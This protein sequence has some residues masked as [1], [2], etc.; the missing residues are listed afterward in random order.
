MTNQS[1]PT[2]NDIKAIV[3]DK[4][5]SFI[6]LQFVDILGHMKNVG[7]TIAEL[8]RVLAQGMVFDG[9]SVEGFVRIEESDM[10]LR[11]DP[12]TFTVLPWYEGHNIARMICDVYRPDGKPFLGDPR[13]VLRKV[14]GEA[15]SLGYDFF[16]GPECEFFLFQCDAQGRPTTNTHDEASYFD[17]APTDNGEL[18]RLDMVKTLMEMGFQIEAAHHESGPGQHEIDFKYSDALRAADNIVTFKLAVKVIAKKYGLHAT[19]MPKPLGAECGSGMHCNMSLFKNGT[20]AFFDVAGVNG[21]SKEAYWFMGGLI[22]HAKGMCAITNP[23]VNSYKRLVPGYEAPV[24]IAWSLANRS[25]LVRIPVARGEGTRLELRHPDPTCNPYLALAVMLKAG[26]DGLKNKINPPPAVDRN[27]YNM[28]DEDLKNAGIDRLPA[29]LNLALDALMEDDLIKDTLGSHILEN[30][31]RAKKIEWAD[32]S[33][34]VHP[35]EI[36]RYLKG[37]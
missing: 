24:Y 4:N 13:Y 23:L 25:P 32:Y 36:D 1:K 14:I 20:N 33:G 10:Y 15:K 12:S 22:K 21:L 11:P 7:I 6:R 5:I 28:T 31:M 19:F 37:Y 30:F 3:K 17:L 29:N 34:A 26:L 8:D 9:S 16:V 18:A 35:W 2:S 27:I